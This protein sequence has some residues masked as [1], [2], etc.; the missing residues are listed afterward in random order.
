MLQVV[1]KY[2]DGLLRY[3][4]RNITPRNTAMIISTHAYVTI[5][6]SADCC[7]FECTL[8]ISIESLIGCVDINI[9]TPYLT[10]RMK[11]CGKK[12]CGRIHKKRC[13]RQ[14][15]WVNEQDNRVSKADKDRAQLD[16]CSCGASG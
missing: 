4:A 15:G 7:R 5:N 3:D 13:I 6:S 1:G 12:E 16:A 8:P 2:V 14:D 10:K 11:E 9:N